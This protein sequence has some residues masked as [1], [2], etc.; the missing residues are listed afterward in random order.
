M[1]TY[2][3]IQEEEMR[4]LF[5]K[6]KENIDVSEE[7]CFDHHVKNGIVIRCM[8]SINYGSAR[9]VGQDAIRIFAVDTVR[10]KGYIKTKRVYRT[11]NWKDNVVKAYKKV[12]EDT[13]NRMK[14]EHKL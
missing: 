4:N 12:Y 5:Y 14:R 1:G 2:V 10:D 6:W 7:L 9:A 11:T 13:K 3:E 8:T